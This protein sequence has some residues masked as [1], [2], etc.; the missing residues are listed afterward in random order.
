MNTDIHGKG[1]RHWNCWYVDGDKV[2][3]FDSYGRHPD[4]PTLPFYFQS[5]SE[6]FRKIQFSERR[7][8]AWDS[9][10]CGYFC[11]QFI[12]TFSLGLDFAS[13]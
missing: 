1:G 2:N 4:D 5:Y 12:Y 7:I 8:Q 9:V 6:N 13:F 10:A 3:F 11:T